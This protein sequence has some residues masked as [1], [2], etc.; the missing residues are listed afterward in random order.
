MKDSYFWS[1]EMIGG[2]KIDETN[3][4]LPECFI[5]GVTQP[6]L[7]IACRCNWLRRSSFRAYFD[8]QSDE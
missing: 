3:F 1:L 5:F 7:P 6:I 2:E 4:V 8:H